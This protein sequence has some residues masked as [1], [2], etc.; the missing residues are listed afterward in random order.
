MSP[1]GP[2]PV[3]FDTLSGGLGSD[4]FVLGGTY[5]RSVAT[6][7]TSSYICYLGAGY[8]TITDWNQASD[9]LQLAG[10]SST[11]SSEDGTPYSL[12]S[13]Q[14]SGRS[15]TDTGLYLGNDLIAVF[16][17]TTNVNLNTHVEWY[18]SFP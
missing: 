17:D 4:T 5:T 2:I 13:G 1:N 7:A 6:G 12:R 18:R 3:G 15:S 9:Y 8:A 14:W 16:Q 11:K 10:N